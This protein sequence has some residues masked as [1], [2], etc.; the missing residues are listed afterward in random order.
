[1]ED[2]K[3]K[4]GDK[5]ELANPRDTENH[6]E[7]LLGVVVEQEKEEF[8]GKTYLRYMVW[9]EGDYEPETRYE[10]EL[11]HKEKSE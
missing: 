6:Y 9:F 7:G 3:F 4:F 1:M 8:E 2:F 11:K 5:V 10:P